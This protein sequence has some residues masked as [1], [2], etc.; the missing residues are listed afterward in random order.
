MN[1]SLLM[2][3]QFIQTMKDNLEIWK[4]EAQ[5]FSDMRVAWDWI[6]YN[7]RLLSINY[8]KEEAEIKREKE[9][10][11][12][13]LKRSFRKILLRKWKRYWMIVNSS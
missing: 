11:S 9:E 1:T 4:T 6:K 13:M 2:D 7:T 12:K 5:Q 3:E 8:S 10:N